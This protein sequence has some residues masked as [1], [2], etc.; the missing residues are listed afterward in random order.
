LPSTSIPQTLR[1]KLAAAI[2]AE[3]AALAL[4]TGVPDATSGKL[5]FSPAVEKPA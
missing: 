4:L 1:D 5:Q 2:Q 3:Q